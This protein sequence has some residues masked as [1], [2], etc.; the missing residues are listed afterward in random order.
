M[1]NDFA[2]DPRYPGFTT[3]VEQAWDGV[4]ASRAIRRVVR[5][6]LEILTASSAKP[7][8]QLL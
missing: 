6:A 2:V 4:K 7:I 3:S 5:K 8:T 1:L